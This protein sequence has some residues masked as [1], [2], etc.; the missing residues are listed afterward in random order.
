MIPR[1][2]GTFLWEAEHVGVARV[3]AEKRLDIYW[4]AP[5]REDDVQ[6]Q[7][8]IIN[9]AMSRGAKGL[10][11]APIEARPLVASVHRIVQKGTP[12]VVIGTDLGIETG[13]RLAYVLSDDDQ[14]G[15]L[16]AKHLGRLLQGKGDI[17][18]LGIN[19]SLTGMAARAASFDATLANEFPNIHVIHRSLAMLNVSQEQQIAEK[20]LT[21]DAQIDAIVALN[22]SS[23]RG[24][25]YALS[26]AGKVGAI[27]IIGF[28]QDMLAQLRNGGIDALVVQDTNRMG[29]EAMMLMDE[30]L[31]GKASRSYVLVPPYLAT[32]A[33]MDTDDMRRMVDLDWFIR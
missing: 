19:R 17:A 6:G 20:L 3:A 32:R 10:I 26:E 7:I 23:T 4:N 15:R 29:R 30:E 24:A 18:I 31:R 33:T 12:V 8:E 1:T 13:E 11:L 2:C 9:R 27:H 25:Y 5:M 28:D 21:E 14:A 22:E 16:A